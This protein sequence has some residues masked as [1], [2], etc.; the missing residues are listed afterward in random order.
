MSLQAWTIAEHCR[1]EF[2]PIRRHSFVV[3]FSSSPIVVIFRVYGPRLQAA[4][5]CFK[6]FG[7]ISLVPLPRDGKHGSVAQ[8]PY[9]R[10]IAAFPS[11]RAHCVS[12]FFVDISNALVIQRL[13]QLAG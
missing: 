13:P 9:A 3:A 7:G 1:A 11:S 4:V 5:I 10:P 12:G 2:S 8:T 6:D